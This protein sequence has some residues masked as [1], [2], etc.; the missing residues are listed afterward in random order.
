MKIWLTNLRYSY[1]A[2][3]IIFMNGVKFCTRREGMLREWMQCQAANTDLQCELCQRH[4][5]KN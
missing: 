3:T 4:K 5:I 2:P 1:Q